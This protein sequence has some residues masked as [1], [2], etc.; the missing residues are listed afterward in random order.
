MGSTIRGAELRFTEH[1][2]GRGARRL[3]EK[4]TELGTDVFTLTVLETG[5][6]DQ[7]VAE[8]RWYDELITGAGET[9]NG[10]RP[11]HWIRQGPLTEQ[12]KARLRA[13][14]VG[15]RGKTQSAEMKAKASATQRGRAKS[16]AHRAACS[17]GQLR[18]WAKAREAA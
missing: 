8:Q 2:K 18:R 4:I 10:R 7:F 15:M 3:T 13:N 14:H 1:V 12:A 11:G 5:E 16:E 6:G 17:A 9:L